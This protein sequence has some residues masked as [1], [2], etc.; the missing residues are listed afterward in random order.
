MF[1]RTAVPPVGPSE[2]QARQP[3]NMA[4]AFMMRFLL[5]FLVLIAG[6]MESSTPPNPLLGVWKSDHDLTMEF[7]R[8]NVRMEDKAERFLDS[9]MGHMT[10]T[11]SESQMKLVF[12]DI[13]VVLPSGTKLTPGFT[14]SSE[15]KVIYSSSQVVVISSTD[16]KDGKASVTTYNFVIDSLMWAYSGGADPSVP[17]IHIREFFRRV[18]AN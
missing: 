12:P 5:I 1:K 15:Y 14:K 8:K 13:E 10:L 3:L 6:C 2:H 17:D 7:I 4:L 9:L 16:P 18:K 11:F